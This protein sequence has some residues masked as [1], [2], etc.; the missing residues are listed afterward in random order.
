VK[1]LTFELDTV[2]CSGLRKRISIA[3]GFGVGV[4]TDHV[5]RLKIAQE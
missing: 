1:N 5:S 3:D 2:T 4:Q